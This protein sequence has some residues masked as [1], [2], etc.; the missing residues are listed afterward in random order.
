MF[1]DGRP[2]EE[3]RDLESILRGDKGVQTTMNWRIQDWDKRQTM[4]WEACLSKYIRFQRGSNVRINA[5]STGAENNV[6][7]D[8]TD[9]IE[10]KY[11]Y[12]VRPTVP[13]KSEN[14]GS[15]TI[16]IVFLI[17]LLLAMLIG[18]L[19]QTTTYN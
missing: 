8:V 12:Y 10:D 5:D 16:K 13:D 7:R 9:N 18:Y 3:C 1:G 14:N 17:V 15:T 11:F 4:Q 2:E 6:T 19:N